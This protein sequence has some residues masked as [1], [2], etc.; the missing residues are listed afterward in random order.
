[1]YFYGSYRITVFQMPKHY[2]IKSFH[3]N[4][5]LCKQDGNL[6][7]QL[8]LKKKNHRAIYAA[9]RTPRS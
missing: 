6:F 9:A 8:L 3:P 7:N 5:G 1:M 4:I 2:K